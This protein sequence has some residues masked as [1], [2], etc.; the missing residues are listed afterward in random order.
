RPEDQ[1]A[2]R[3]RQV[4]AHRPD[5][6]GQD[7]RG[8]TWLC[9]PGGRPPGLLAGG[10]APSLSYGR[11]RGI[12]ERHEPRQRPTKAAAMSTVDSDLDV[13]GAAGDAGVPGTEVTA[14]RLARVGDLDVRRLLPLRPRRSVGAWC[15]VDPYGP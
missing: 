12:I 1:H 13:P 11:S 2:V 7:S 10:R 5:R 4:G 6:L 15:F 8:L 3:R 14:A 9:Q